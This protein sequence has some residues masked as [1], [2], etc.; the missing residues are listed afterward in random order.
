MLTTWDAAPGWNMALDEA[1]LLKGPTDVSVL[2]FYTWSP[3]T[4]SLGYFQRLADVPAAQ[5][6]FDAYGSGRA[7]DGAATSEARPGAVVRRLTG[8]G[9]IHHQHELTF[10]ITAQLDHPL[11]L[12]TTARSYERVHAALASALAGLGVS[13][14]VRGA[15]L[16]RS[17]RDGTGMCFH[18]SAS[19]DL[20]WNGLKGVGSAQRRRGDRVL[21][22]GSIKLGTTPLEG[23]IATLNVTPAAL[24]RAV[25]QAL[26]GHAKANSG[27]PLAAPPA[28]ENVL[29]HAI[30]ASDLDPAVL[31]LATDRQAFFTSAGFLSR[32]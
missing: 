25:E 9:A 3:D 8:G 10:S 23:E 21:H 15:T 31:A 27:A 26:F 2:R 4:L 19:V 24:A 18:K 1:L 5:R 20:V 14:E 16:P 13:A 6:F 7:P 28:V 30:D 32:R 22:H 29:M 17:E 11:Y 12:G